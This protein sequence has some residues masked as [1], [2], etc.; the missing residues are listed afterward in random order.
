MSNL[1][2]KK[3]KM[4]RQHSTRDSNYKI[5]KSS[6]LKTLDK[7]YFMAKLKEDINFVSIKEHSEKIFGDIKV[8]FIF[9]K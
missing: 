2:Q 8:W 3:R 9:Q 4:Q 5:K 7:P 1:L 6:A